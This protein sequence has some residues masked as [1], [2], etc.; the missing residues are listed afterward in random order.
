MEKNYEIAYSQSTSPPFS[1]WL[2][3]LNPLQ[4]ASVCL[5]AQ[6]AGIRAIFH[7]LYLPTCKRLPSH[8]LPASEAWK[9]SLLISYLL[10]FLDL[11][12][13]IYSCCIYEFHVVFLQFAFFQV[14]TCFVVFQPFFN[15]SWVASYHFPVYNGVHSISQCSTEVFSLLVK[16][17]ISKYIYTQTIRPPRYLQWKTTF[18]QHTM[19]GSISCL[20]LCLF[21][22][23]QTTTK[24]LTN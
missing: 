4:H 2:L 1:Y 21:S 15:L 3:F 10:S 8:A 11:F 6:Y 7:M 12:N 22:K 24:G 23:T 16:K 14:G 20:L 13:T 18:M 19:S 5:E 17:K 9:I